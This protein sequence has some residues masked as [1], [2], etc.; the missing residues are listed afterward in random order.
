MTP[1]ELS[2]AAFGPNHFALE[3]V[4]CV[5]DH[6]T[7]TVWSQ[8]TPDFRLSLVQLWLAHNPD[9]LND[10]SAYSLDR[11]ELARRLASQEP[12]HPLFQHLAR[13]SLRELN[14]S[15]SGLDIGQIGPG[16]RPRPIGPDLELVR[17]FYL[18]DLDRD[19]HGNY[20]FAS[21]AT[22]GAAS[23]LV[24]RAGSG[25]AVAGVGEWLLR[26]GWPP[27]HERVAQSDD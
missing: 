25:W 18:P 6:R 19:D 17:L 11:D 5:V 12:E 7:D 3:W 27:T 20:V 14:N 24:E 2:Q 10:P 26:P 9:A 21:G 4:R 13:V 1:E 16:A 22:A 23:V 15:F 8:M